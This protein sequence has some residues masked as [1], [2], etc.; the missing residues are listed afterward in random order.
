MTSYMTGYV[1]PLT[2]WIQLLA[3]SMVLGKADVGL[4]QTILKLLIN[5]NLR[6]I[7]T[8]YRYLISV[9][10]SHIH[11]LKPIAEFIIFCISNNS[12]KLIIMSPTKCNQSHISHYS[13]NMQHSHNVLKSTELPSSIQISILPSGLQII[14][15]NPVNILI[16]HVTKYLLSNCI[17]NNDQSIDTEYR[18]VIMGKNNDFQCILS[19]SEQHKF[20]LG[21]D[22]LSLTCWIVTYFLPTAKYQCQMPKT[23]IHSK[24]TRSEFRR[25]CLD[26][27]PK[28]LARFSNYFNVCDAAKRILFDD[29]AGGNSHISE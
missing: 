7:L 26:K 4:Y 15:Y 18:K 11:Q 25:Y 8:Q 1:P 27:M 17:I 14:D 21:L 6:E 22:S 29:N 9:L 23:S 2:F 13:N 3:L 10:L 19:N 5:Y 16:S 12:S 28:Q 20:Y 24:Q